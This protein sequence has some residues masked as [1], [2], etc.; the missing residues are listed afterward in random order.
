MLE[1]VER[2]R[3]PRTPVSL[4]VQHQNEPG[5]E[6]E[7]DYATDL[8]PGGLFI[9]TPRPARRGQT[10]QVQFAPAKD[11]HLIQAYCQVMR[12]THEGMGAAFVQLDAES[13]MELAR[14]LPE[15]TPQNS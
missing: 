10:L 11:S 15:Q 5:G 2:R 8:S 1:P 9:R 7:V 14:A 4:L 6:P 3:H 13:A 12:V